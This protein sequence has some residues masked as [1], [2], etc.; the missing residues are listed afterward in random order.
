MLDEDISVFYD[1][2]ATEFSLG[3]SSPAVT[4][5]AIVGEVDE[6]ALDGYVS[7]TERQIRWPT[8]WATLTKGQ[9]LTVASGPYTGTWRVLR[10]GVKVNDGRESVSYI[11]QD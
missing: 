5:Q 9:T 3:G 10:D 4:F 11:G 8:P 7:G 1:D 6:D 2:F